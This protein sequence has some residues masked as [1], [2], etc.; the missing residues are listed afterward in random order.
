MRK[1]TL[2]LYFHTFSIIMTK[3][4]RPVVSNML[5]S[6]IWKCF[7][8]FCSARRVYGYLCVYV[9]FLYV[10]LYLCLCVHVC[11][12]VCVCVCVC[13]FKHV[14]NHVYFQ[15]SCTCVQSHVC[16]QSHGSS[17]F[18]SRVVL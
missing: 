12:R 2:V 5:F 7:F 1:H 9:H 4:Y 15:S 8:V 6:G 11:V 3:Y 18:W 13:S 17:W 10:C 14:F 16:V